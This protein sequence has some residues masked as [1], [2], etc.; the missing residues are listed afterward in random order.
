MQAP[1]GDPGCYRGTPR[2]ATRRVCP[3]G[4]THRGSETF[5][6]I[7]GSRKYS[8]NDALC[9]QSPS[10]M[11]TYLYVVQGAPWRLR[12]SAQARL[13]SEGCTVMAD[14]GGVRAPERSGTSKPPNRARGPIGAH[15]ALRV[16]V[17]GAPEGREQGR[18][19]RAQLNCALFDR[20]SA[21]PAFGGSCQGGI[22]VR[23]SASTYISYKPATLRIG[24]SITAP[25][26]RSHNWFGSIGL[27]EVSF[28]DSRSPL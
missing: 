27:A 10:W 20:R 9:H 12:A 28:Q 25:I 8:T 14:L 5:Y 13:R 11:F 1:G 4:D 24:R 26:S 2:V 7:L 17:R 23:A 18:S 19:N 16:P 6:R 22:P 15:C 21:P 3:I